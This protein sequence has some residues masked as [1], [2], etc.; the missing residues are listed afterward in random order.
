MLKPLPKSSYSYSSVPIRL[1]KPSDDKFCTSFDISKPLDPLS[2]KSL[3]L[4][5]KRSLGLCCSVEIGFSQ[6]INTKIKNFTF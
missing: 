4:E 5:Q 1:F 2:T 6:V 3:T